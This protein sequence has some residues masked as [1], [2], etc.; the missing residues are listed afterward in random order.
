MYVTSVPS[1][2]DLEMWTVKKLIVHDFFFFFANI[3]VPSSRRD[4]VILNRA[5]FGAGEGGLKRGFFTQL[6]LSWD[7]LCRPGRI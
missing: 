3:V 7:S 1:K 4:C 5:L 2:L 6:W